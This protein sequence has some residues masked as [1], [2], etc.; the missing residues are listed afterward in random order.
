MHS[1]VREA[2]GLDHGRVVLEE[3]LG[4]RVEAGTIAIVQAH[5]GERAARHLHARLA[6]R[7]VGRHG[8]AGTGHVRR[9]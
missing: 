8:S 2:R 3:I 7:A 4:G 1:Y 6:H 5:Q 9:R